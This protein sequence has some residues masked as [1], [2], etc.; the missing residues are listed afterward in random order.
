MRV[1]SAVAAWIGI[2]NVAIS[3]IVATSVFS[4]LSENVDI[5]IKILTGVIALVAAILAA[6]QAFL[7]FSERAEKYKAAGA[8]YGKVR[9]DIDVFCL[10]FA[11]GTD[12]QTALS[13]LQEIGD[14]LGALAGE[15]PTLSEAVY[16]AAKDDFDSTH[17]V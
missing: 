4:T 2:P 3:A 10:R 13:R 9:R 6:L 8:R 15:S 1:A 17:E 7:N 12:R 14:T 11:N 16:H 5:R